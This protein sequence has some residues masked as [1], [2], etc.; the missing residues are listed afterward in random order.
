MNDRGPIGKGGWIGLLLLINSL[1]K[2]ESVYGIRYEFLEDILP[3]IK[4][5]AQPSVPLGNMFTNIIGNESAK[6][7]LQ[8]NSI[9]E[10]LYTEFDKALPVWIDKESLVLFAIKQAVLSELASLI[11][12]SIQ[13]SDFI[14]H[15]LAK[16]YKLDDYK[17]VSS[18]TTIETE[19]KNKER[20]IFRRGSR[21]GQQEL[22]LLLNSSEGTSLNFDTSLNTNTPL[23]DSKT[24]RIQESSQIVSGWI[25]DVT[26]PG[27]DSD[28]K[29]LVSQSSARD[30]NNFVFSEERFLYVQMVNKSGMSDSELKE[31]VRRYH[32]PALIPSI[33]EIVNSLS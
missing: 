23:N 8:W 5:E 33:I 1:K 2:E 31:F 12:S 15:P 28:Y 14:N 7:N 17:I 4:N 10:Q 27:L 30:F 26:Y 3:F 25:A 20:L 9:R 16:I 24:I 29:G 22:E 21:A 6:I 18:Y 13:K 19:F 32:L 11:S